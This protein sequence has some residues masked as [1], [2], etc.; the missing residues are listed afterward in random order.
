MTLDVGF[1]R[2]AALPKE[3][4]RLKLLD[5]LKV[6]NNPLT[7]PPP[8]VVAQGTKAILEFLRNLPE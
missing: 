8:E 7:M 6:G 3:L 5:T 1:N 4:S 2:L